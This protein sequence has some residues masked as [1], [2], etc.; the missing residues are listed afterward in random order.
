MDCATK[1][2]KKHFKHYRVRARVENLF[3]E[4]YAMSVRTAT[5]DAGGTYLYDNLGVPQTLHF[6]YSYS[7]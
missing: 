7:F 4:D 1:L 2:L 6:F 3:D 5:A